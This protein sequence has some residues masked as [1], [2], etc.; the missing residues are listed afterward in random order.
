MG[1]QTEISPQVPV[2]SSQNSSL[3]TLASQFTILNPDKERLPE[4]S[5]EMQLS[6]S[7][8]N[9]SF[10]GCNSRSS[11]ICRNIGSTSHRVDISVEQNSPFYGTNVNFD[12][13]VTSS[14]LD[15]QVL[16]E[17][18]CMDSIELAT[19]RTETS[20]STFDGNKKDKMAPFVCPFNCGDEQQS[21][22]SLKYHI[23]LQHSKKILT[24]K[25]SGSDEST[26]MQ[27]LCPFEC[28]ADPFKTQSDQKHHL[29]KKH[30]CTDKQLTPAA[31]QSSSSKDPNY[32][33]LEEREAN[34]KNIRKTF[35]SNTKGLTLYKF[36]RL[37]TEND[38]HKVLVRG[39]GYCFLSCIIIA[40]AEHG[41]KKTLEVLSTEVM[42]HIRE[43]KDY[44]YSSFESVS[45]SENESENLIECCARYFQGAAYNTNSVDVCIA[46]VVKTLGV[47]LNLFMKDPV[48]KLMTLSKYDCNECNSTVNFFLHYYPGSKQGKCL[49]AHY[50]CYANVMTDNIMSDSHPGEI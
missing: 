6:S 3:E 41:K 28:G 17:Q 49:D 12:P 38:L 16:K 48:M 31:T 36:R 1:R 5:H 21:L 14:S 29:M 22:A 50:N 46:A 7:Q 9:S 18:I 11:E 42:S 19:P 30:T 34:E 32:D 4:V 44:F 20:S 23:Q 37:L 10:N 13:L 27:L 26:D 47:N 8:E 2:N 25:I 39:N 40:L 35:L 43:N 33:S 45:K 15:E 24:R